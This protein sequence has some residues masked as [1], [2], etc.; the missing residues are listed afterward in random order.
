[1]DV[2]IR[3]WPIIAEV[4]T[5]SQE[6]AVRALLDMCELEYDWREDDTVRIVTTD[7]S[8]ILFLKN[9]NVKVKQDSGK[10][11]AAA[12]LYDDPLLE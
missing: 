1:M 4:E 2:I 8:Q 9:R 11:P 5:Y 10:L 7:P 3:K 12:F 6:K